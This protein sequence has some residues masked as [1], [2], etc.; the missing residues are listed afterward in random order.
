MGD[1]KMR[2]DGG[3]RM[4]H[5]GGPTNRH[6]DVPST[7]HQ[8]AP[9]FSN[10]R[11]DRFHYKSWDLNPEHVPK[12]RAYF[13]HDNRDDEFMR[14]RSRGM[15]QRG[16]GTHGRGTMR[17]RPF[18]GGAPTRNFMGRG[19]RGYAPRKSSPDFNLDHGPRE[20]HYRA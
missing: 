17:G 7:F 20:R 1:G 14:G 4:M 12:G 6:D 5:H 10:Q 16:S 13:E 9:E 8:E 3:G 15:G 19:R 2:S 11:S 18:R